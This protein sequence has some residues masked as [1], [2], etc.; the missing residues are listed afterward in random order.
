MEKLPVE[1]KQHI[2]GLL[3]DNN[4][5]S[6]R[7]LDKTWA[8]IA[9]LHLSEEILITPLSL[10]RLRLIAQH[11]VITRCVKPITFYAELL[12]SILPEMWHEHRIQRDLRWGMK[13]DDSLRFR[14]YV[15][16]HREQQR[17]REN[18][19]N[20]TRMIVN[21]SIPMLKRL[22]GL[23]LATGGPSISTTTLIILVVQMNNGPEFVVTWAAISQTH[24]E[25]HGGRPRFRTIS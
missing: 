11:E 2:C 13:E 6:V 1:L 25:H 24:V 7:I 15:L 19:Y 9:A 4:L 22:Q 21:L 5:K 8:N 3:D 14:R 16:A 10:E 17:L 18:N 23:K 20:L 12:P